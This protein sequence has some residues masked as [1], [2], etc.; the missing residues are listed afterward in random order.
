M[1]QLRSKV[2]YKKNLDQTKKKKGKN[3]EFFEAKKKIKKKLF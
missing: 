3:Q 2:L 1:F